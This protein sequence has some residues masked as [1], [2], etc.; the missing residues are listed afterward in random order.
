VLSSSQAKATFALTIPY[1]F[2]ETSVHLGE[3]VQA[4]KINLAAAFGGAAPRPPAVPSPAA[5]S[6]PVP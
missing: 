2:I 3:F 5:P 1:K 6:V 4:Q